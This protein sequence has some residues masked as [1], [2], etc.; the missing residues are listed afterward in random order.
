VSTVAMRKLEIVALKRDM[1]SVLECLGHAGCFQIAPP[2]ATTSP[3][4]RGSD[5]GAEEGGASLYRASLEALEELRRSLDLEYP[6]TVSAGT[7]LPGSAEEAALVAMRGRAKVIVEALKSN[8]EKAAK[9]REAL[10]EARVFAGL[11]LP[12]RELDRLSFLSVRI[13]RV[14]PEELH[15][16][17]SALGE[18]AIAIAVGK[19][20]DIV[21]VSSRKG[22][23]ALDTE[24]TRAG[25]V[26]RQF[27]ADFKGVPPELPAA[28]ERGLSELDAERTFLEREREDLREE[29]TEPWAALAASFVVASSVEEARISLESSTQAYR[30]EGWVPSDLAEPLVESIAAY[31]GGR[32]AVRAY[33]PGEL[34]AVSSGEEEVPVLLKR[35]PFVS[36]FERMVL[37]FGTPRYGSVD[38]TPFVCAFFV[39]FFTIM[40]GDLGQGFLILA[41]AFALR[42]GLVPSLLKWK[43]FAPIGI[44][45]GIGSML[46]GLLTGSCFTFENLLVPLTR[47]LSSALLGHP[48]D[49]FLVLMPEGGSGKVLIFFG[50]TLA[51]GVVVNSTGLVINI[52]NKIRAGER[53]EALFSKTGLAG[54]L[55]FWWAVAMGLRAILGSKPAWF[56]ALGLGLPL[57]ALIFEEPFA[58]LVD[59]RRSE[60]GSSTL[61]HGSRDR[62]AER[63]RGDG[64]FASVVKGFVAILESVS[65]FLSNSLSFLR[66][67]AFALSHAVLSF[68]VFTMGDMVRQ[69]SDLGFIGQ[70]LIVL[71]GN[72]IIL[73]LEG[74]IVAIQIV[75]LQYYEFLSKFLTETGSPFLPF[76][77]QFRKEQP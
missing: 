51:L 29:L 64:A 73:F 70:I 46:M 17:R 69:R 60:H 50:F 11:E 45:C 21:A 54:A 30:L 19:K 18:R 22:R 32:V 35:R 76:K 56:D 14:D 67:G 34:E 47:A 23:F 12:Y 26:P 10:E 31:A 61:G 5:E 28:L 20:G 37:S 13:G 25:F 48:V 3:E 62:D 24:L 1:N 8:A 9:A 66:V 63:Q 33:E 15:A 58:E 57:L 72:A 2:R 44:A 43:A 68:I 42:L 6:R 40:F 55:L 74:L 38:P 52:V 75:R 53:G 41:G 77:F 71:V 49:R 39:L 4:P 36:S 59:S 65:Y 16:I 7:L 27:S